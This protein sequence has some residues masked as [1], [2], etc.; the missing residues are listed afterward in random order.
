LLL[1]V[2]LCLPGAA[3]AQAP[4]PRG[5]EGSV[6]M[7]SAEPRDSGLKTGVRVGLYSVAAVSL[8]LSGVYGWKSL[9]ARNEAE[10]L[11]ELEPAGFCAGL[12]RPSCK[13]YMDHRA[14]QN[15][16]ALRSV[17]LLGVS[18]FS[19][20]ASLAVQEF[21]V[22][23]ESTSAKAP[24]ALEAGPLALSADVGSEHA[25]LAITVGF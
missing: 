18:V 22:T 16:Q 13:E 7:P 6:S 5:A 14:D 1:G 9:E 20:L 17:G 10:T 15:T 25:A 24:S 11:K 3:R 19:V 4:E 12:V 2:L 21:W 23:G 8:V